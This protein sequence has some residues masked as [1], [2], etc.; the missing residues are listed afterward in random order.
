V[1]RNVPG[2]SNQL[3]PPHPLLPKRPRVQSTQ[4][5]VR[6]CDNSYCDSPQGHNTAD[7]IS[8]KGT[9]EGQYA[10]WWR[11]PWNIHLPKAQRTTE[12]NLPPKT[13]PAYA[14]W[15]LPSVSHSHL[16]DH[17]SLHRAATNPLD[18]GAEET[19]PSDPNQ[20]PFYA[21]TTHLDD[22]IMV[23]TLPVLDASLTRENHCHHDSGANRHVFHDRNVFEK[24]HSIPPL[25]VKGFGKNLSAVAIGYGNVRLEGTY[26]SQKCAILL[27]NVLHI[28]AARSNL[29]S[30]IQLDRAG[31]LSTLGN[32]TVILSI[33]GNPIVGGSIVNDMYRLNLNVIHPKSVPTLLSRLGPT[34]HASTSQ[35]VDFYIA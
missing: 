35:S 13:H 10:D 28:P 2:H 3:L 32:N 33:S 23:A 14:K 31:V 26:R 18:N 22:E 29:I 4:K 1:L 16:P 5:P 15:T 8:Y 27:E 9:K 30:G 34:P 24:Y 7:C 12:N 17:D 21:W 20:T 19:T 6:K 25:T 11:G